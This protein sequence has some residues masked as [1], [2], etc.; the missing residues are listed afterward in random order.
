MPSV[1]EISYEGPI[2]IDWAPAT[3]VDEVLQNARFI[4]GTDA[5]TV[6]LVR[7]LGIS[8]SAVDAPMSKARA[9]LMTNTLRSMRYEPRISVREIAIEGSAAL[10]GRLTPRIKVAL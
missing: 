2:E 5:G 1:Y 6:P 10:D 3:E 4:L 7:G 9:L 8:A